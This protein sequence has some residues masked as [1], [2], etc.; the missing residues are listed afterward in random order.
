MKS[1]KKKKKS[2][3]SARVEINYDNNKFAFVVSKR[4]DY[5]LKK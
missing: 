1:K 3:L 4:E 5:W 2:W